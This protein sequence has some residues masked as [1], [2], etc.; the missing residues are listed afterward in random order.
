MWPMVPSYLSHL[1]G[2]TPLGPLWGQTPR[3]AAAVGGLGP[4]SALQVGSKNH[5]L[6]LES[7][8]APKI[9]H[10]C[11]GRSPA[12]GGRGGAG[13]GVMDVA[14]GHRER[15]KLWYGCRVTWTI[16]KWRGKG[17]KNAVVHKRKKTT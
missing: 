16:G 1:R 4:C 5:Q 10:P 12:R 8:K 15:G 13:N 9:S 17:R 7:I 11:M 2:Q 6:C 14:L 3:A